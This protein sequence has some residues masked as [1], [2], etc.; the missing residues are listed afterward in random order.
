MITVYLVF[1]LNISGTH[2]KESQSFNNKP[3]ACFWASRKGTQAFKL[4]ILPNKKWIFQKLN[5]TS[6]E[7]ES[8][9]IIDV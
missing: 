9:Q 7:N 5:C 6:Q 8:T 1:W 4:T 2:I 3:D